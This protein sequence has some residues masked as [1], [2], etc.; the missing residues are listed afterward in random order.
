MAILSA[1]H[2]NWITAS[3]FWLPG[4]N[5]TSIRAEHLPFHFWLIDAA[6][7]QVI[8]DLVS[9]KPD[10]YLAF[11]QSLDRLGY[12]AICLGTQGIFGGT[13]HERSSLR[14]YHDRHFAHLSHLVSEPAQ[15]IGQLRSRAVDLLHIDGRQASEFSEQDA[16][17]WLARLSP[18]GLILVDEPRISARSMDRSSSERR[19]PFVIGGTSNLQLSVADPVQNSILAPLFDEAGADAAALMRA[20]FARLGVSLSVQARH[21]DLET[22]S[23]HLEVSL[24][25][26]SAAADLLRE[27]NARLGIDAQAQ[28]LEKATLATRAEEIGRE[29]SR[30][31][32]H[33]GRLEIEIRRREGVVNDRDGEIERLR[34]HT[35]GLETEVHRLGRLVAD[36]D[37]EIERLRSHTGGLETEVHR[38][39]RLVADRD[40]E[41]ERLHS[42]TGGLETEV[43]RLERLVA[44]RD[45]EIMRLEDRAQALTRQNDAEI[46]RLQQLAAD[47]EGELQEARH[48]AAALSV[49]LQQSQQSLETSCS[50]TPLASSDDVLGDHAID[51]WHVA[52]DRTDLAGFSDIFP[53]RPVLRNAE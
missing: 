1:Q 3:L 32:E 2:P 14:E 29:V 51:G 13:R 9:G 11:C 16:R 45:Q 41:I 18:Q 44:D 25:Q 42:H 5:F 7:P 8:V 15:L 27:Q 47:R 36:R 49:S 26:Q 4:W 40:G 30:L 53:D 38:L 48:H 28:S 6:R 24:A 35:G 33:A 52:S 20:V 50:V 43:H 23:A 34:S 10:S 19:A 21:R 46:S 37:G 39:G 22:Y 31:H 12:A 17:S